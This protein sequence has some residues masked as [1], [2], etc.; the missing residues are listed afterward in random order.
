[1][2][3]LKHHLIPLLI[4]LIFTIAIWQIAETLIADF[5]SKTCLSIFG[6]SFVEMPTMDKNGI[7]MRYY[8]SAG[9][10][11]DP[12]LIAYESSRFYKTRIEEPRK[13]A[14]LLYSKWLEEH[15]DENGNIPHNYDYPKAHLKKPW[16]SSAS[17]SATMLALTERAGNLRSPETF[18][19]ARKM[20]YT[21]QPEK[22]N[23]S[24]YEKKG[25]IWFQEFPTEP[26]SLSGMLKTLVNLSEYYKLVDDSLSWELFQQ[27]VIA[28][29]AK[30]PELAKKNL[31]DDKYHYKNKRSEHLELVA[32]LEE[33]NSATPDSVFTPFIQK[34]QAKSKQFV[35]FQF[36][37]P[38]QPG[39]ILGFL[40]GWA[41]LY[42]LADL[43][44]KPLRT[45][46]HEGERS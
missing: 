25:G 27:G 18:I 38:F 29:Q 37:S 9:K 24:F 36:F 23:F 34:Y 1:M 12:E 19:K 8:P 26:Y 20:L 44:F 33:V 45:G 15:L 46:E 43:F 10:V 35:L 42:L 21:L 5:W 41:V 3:K 13:N 30:L 4:G 22:G 17:H 39:R 28:L 31:L 16:F 7:P 11:Y 14:F 40:I 6:S 32:L 2:N